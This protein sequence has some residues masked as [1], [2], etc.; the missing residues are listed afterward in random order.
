MAGTGTFIFG[1]IQLTVPFLIIRKETIS[2][3][4]NFLGRKVIL[5]SD[6][7]EIEIDN[8]HIVIKKEKGSSKIKIKTIGTGRRDEVIGYFNSLKTIL[9]KK[10]NKI[11]LN[12]G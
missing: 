10:E 8:N 6:I 1:I 5:H 7:K 3:D 2:I 4:N 11:F 9:L 12:Q